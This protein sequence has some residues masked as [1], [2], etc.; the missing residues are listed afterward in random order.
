MQFSEIEMSPAVAYQMGRVD[1]LSGDDAN[2]F[3]ARPAI[4]KEIK[5]GEWG[6]SE[7]E[8]LAIDRIRSQYLAGYDS[9][10]QHDSAI[11]DF[12]RKLKSK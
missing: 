8:A 12:A 5:N 6:C 9:A 3:T 11:V 1:A 4:A 2:R 7:N 10:E